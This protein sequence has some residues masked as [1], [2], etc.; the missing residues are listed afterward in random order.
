MWNPNITTTATKSKCNHT[1]IINNIIVMFIMFSLCT[2]VSML[3]KKN[4]SLEADIVM[5]YLLGIIL[6]SYWASG[7]FYSFLAS[8]CGILLYNYFF[9]EP[10]YTF[11]VYNPGYPITFLIMFMVSAFTSMLTI[12]LKSQTALAEER[13][14]RFKALYKIEKNLL[15]VKSSTSL[16]KISAEQLAKQFNADVLIQ[17]FE[18]S[19]KPQTRYVVGNDFFHNDK[20]RL[21]CY[22]TY[23]SG[24]SCG[25][26]TKLFSQSTAYYLPIIGLNG[27]LGVIGVA[28][29]DTLPLTPLQIKFLD[30][31]AP[32]IAVVLERERL[33][34]KQEETRM[35]VQRER[36]RADMLRAISHDLRTPLT[37]IMGSAST[38]I[39]NYATI[40]DDIKKNFL[41]SIYDD[42]EWLNEM[43]ENILNMTRF[44]E[45]KVTLNIEQEAAEE[46]I[47]EAISHVKK[48]AGEHIISA[49]I[50]PEI[51]LLNV[52]GVLI[53]QVLVNLLGNAI[54]YTPPG[55]EINISVSNCEKKVVFEVSDNGPGISETDLP[56][57]FERFYSPHSKQSGTRHGTGLGLSLCKSIIEAHGGKISLNNAQPHGTLVRFYLPIK[58][59]SYNATLGLNR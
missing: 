38:V 28:L 35:Q 46:L 30:T 45:G 9:T 53:T 16:A 49:H 42:A 11:Q 52:D 43:V 59:A 37:G 20:E 15:G 4:N 8:I 36:L 39:D 2:I 24:N 26:G 56:H 31:V 25:Y 58:E 54:K 57:L 3:F 17:F 55:S 51:I 22:E 40:S 34:E 23:Q 50:P 10:Y 18:T 32:Q 48:L 5:V 1:A 19:G 7:Y 13:E 12:R 44:D 21:A 41:R 47:A 27:G 33:Y 29:I 14:Q 6:F